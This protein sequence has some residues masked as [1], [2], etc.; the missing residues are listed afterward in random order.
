MYV[1]THHQAIP[2]VQW[3]V[4][5]NRGSWPVAV[6]CFDPGGGLIDGTVR[7]LTLHGTAITHRT[8]SAGIAYLIFAN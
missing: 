8:L 7:N 2:E 3:N 6:T 1:Y 5:H 4:N